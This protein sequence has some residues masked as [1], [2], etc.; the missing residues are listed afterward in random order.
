MAWLT[1]QR[2]RV[3]D[4]ALS[5]IVEKIDDLP[6]QRTALIFER[7][8]TAGNDAFLAFS[9]AGVQNNFANTDI[10]LMDA[11]GWNTV[12]PDTST[13]LSGRGRGLT[14]AQC[15][16]PEGLAGY[17]A[18]ANGDINSNRIGEDGV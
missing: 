16:G 15:A 5:G 7:T 10:T 18:P 17:F 13:T 12:A 8:A 2:C 9:Q 6:K 1:R 14:L 3:G 4:R 11:I